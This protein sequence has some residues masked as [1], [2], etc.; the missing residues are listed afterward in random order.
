MKIADKN[1]KRKQEETIESEPSAGALRVQ[2]HREKVKVSTLCGQPGKRN[3]RVGQARKKVAAVLDG[4]SPVEKV[5]ALEP[6]F[7]TKYQ[8]NSGRLV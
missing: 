6:T 8:E 3:H 2:K 4:F 5:S 7:D 1:R